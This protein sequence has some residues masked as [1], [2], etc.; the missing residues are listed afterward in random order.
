VFRDSSR[1]SALVMMLLISS[2][3]VNDAITNEGLADGLARWIT[4]LQLSPLAFLLLANVL[5]LELGTILDGAAMLLVCVPVL[6]PSVKALGIDL[7]HF[8]VVA[9]L[10][11][12]I[13][14]ISPPYGLILFVLSSLTKVPM[15]EINRE[16]WWFCLPLTI[17]LFILIGFPSI[18]LILPQL[19][20]MR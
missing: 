13:A 3:L 9:I 11:F 10:N 17:V 15:R 12:M 7:V 2:F 20:G 1:Q 4:S 16:I 6:M 18:T 19:L 5:F 8:G 14:I